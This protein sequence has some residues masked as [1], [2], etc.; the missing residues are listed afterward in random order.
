MTYRSG[1]PVWAGLLIVGTYFVAVPWALRKAAAWLAPALPGAMAWPYVRVPLGVAICALGA[2]V[3]ARGYMVLAHMGKNWPGGR[4]MYLVDTNT[5]RF[6][7][8][9]VF[10]GYTVFWVGRSIIA[11]SWSLLAATGLLAAGFAV[12]AALEERELAQRFGDDFLEYRRSVGAVIPDFAAL[13]EDWRDIPN[14]GLIVITLARPLGEFLWRV[15]AVGMEHIPRKGPVVFASNHMTNADPWAIALFATRMIHFVTADEVFRHPFGRWFFGAQGAIRKKKWTRNVWVLREMK[16]IVDS[17]RAVGIFPQGQYNWDG[18][19]NVVGD[20]V[21]RVLRFLNAPVVPVTFVGAH[22]A[23]PPWSFWPARSDWEV[24]FFEPVHPRDYADV[25]EFR[26]ALDSKMF[27]TNGY[28]PVRRRGFASHKGITVVLWGC[29]RCGG[30]ATLEETRE[31]VRCR[32][33]RS[34]FKVE[35][36]LKIVDKANGRAMTEAQYRSTLLKM[37]ADGKLEDAADG[38]LSLASRAKAYRIESTDLL[39]RVGEGTVSL[40][41]EQLAFAGTSERG[42]AVCLEIPVADVDFTFLNGAGHLV[43]SAGPLGVYQFAL[44]EDSNLRLEDYLMHA[45]AE[46]CACGRRRRRSASGPGAPAPTAGGGRR[47]G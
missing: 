45:R 37:L 11:G 42:E 28:P 17:G 36:D 27:S 39:T 5:Y 19:H 2:Y 10:W 22:E 3:A 47:R 4:T 31:G 1:R 30:A 7:R 38:R 12:V 40:T 43:V 18:G 13:V 33:C 16:R 21:Y 15:R 24:R 44:I 46:L 9:P 6:I 20:E 32:K 23:W 35:P 14:V 25:A 34:E 8:H 26:K 41:N 29:V